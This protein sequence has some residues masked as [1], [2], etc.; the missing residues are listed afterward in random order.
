MEKLIFDAGIK[1]YELGNGILRFN[2]TDPNVYARF[3]DAIPEIQSIGEKVQNENPENP[4][5]MLKVL[6][7]FDRDVKDELNNVFG[8]DNDFHQ[9]LS[10]VNLLAIAS[11]GKNVAENLINALMPILK[12]GVQQYAANEVKAAKDARDERKGV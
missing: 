12:D 6:E 1:E 7:K 10:G 5:D 9:M 2:P 4:E 11:N 3:L 8:G